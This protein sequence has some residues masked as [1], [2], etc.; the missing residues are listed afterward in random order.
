M[1]A[2][3]IRK[4]T[5]YNG[6]DYLDPLNKLKMSMSQRK[7]E[8]TL[9]KSQ[10]R[11]LRKSTSHIIDSYKYGECQHGE[12]Q[13]ELTVNYKD[14][15]SFYVDCYYHCFPLKT[16]DHS[17]YML[18]TNDMIR[19][20]ISHDDDHTKTSI[21]LHIIEDHIEILKSVNE[22]YFTTVLNTY[23]NKDNY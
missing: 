21:L 6:M 8:A 19:N 3:M 11:T 20:A 1:R 18:I 10:Q 16:I 2:S 7:L 17:K 4:S 22:S 5:G 9:S 15:H 14:F 12:C 13:H 23:K